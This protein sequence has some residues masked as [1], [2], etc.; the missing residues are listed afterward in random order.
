MLQVQVTFTFAVANGKTAIVYAKADD[1][2]N[3]NIIEI[4]TALASDVVDDTSPQLG[5]RLRY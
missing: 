3:P 1:G 4:Q 5:G 2:T